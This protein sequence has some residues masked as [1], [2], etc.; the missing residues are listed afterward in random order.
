MWIDFFICLFLG[1]FGVHKFRERK[2][3]MGILYLCTMGLFGIG[4][5]VDCIRY[6]IMALKGEKSDNSNTPPRIFRK[7]KIH[8]TSGWN[9]ADSY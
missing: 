3:G 9:L 2:I 8:F 5:F 6:L 7:F 4:W 1:M